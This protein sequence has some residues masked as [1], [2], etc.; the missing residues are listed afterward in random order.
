MVAKYNV[1][2]VMHVCLINYHYQL[3]RQMFTNL[4][5]LIPIV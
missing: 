1:L 4:Q 5:F 2:A 3:N